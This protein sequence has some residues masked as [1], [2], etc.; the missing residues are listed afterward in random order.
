MTQRHVFEVRY[1]RRDHGVFVELKM[2]TLWRLLQRHRALKCADTDVESGERLKKRSLAAIRKVVAASF[3]IYAICKL[4]IFD[5]DVFLV[6]KISPHYMWVVE[7][8][9]LIL[10]AAVSTALLVT[11]NKYL[12][13]WSLYILF[14]PF[15]LTCWT[16]PRS[17]FKTGDWLFVF[18][19][20]NTIISAFSSIKYKFVAFSVFILSTF[21]IFTSF[22]GPFDRVRHI[23]GE[24]FCAAKRCSR[25]RLIAVGLDLHSL[26]KLAVLAKSSRPIRHQCCTLG[27]QRGEE[28][29]HRR[30]VPDVA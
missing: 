21:A 18:A 7:Y 13:G 6:N 20:A 5:I 26:T 17:A 4:F 14:Y 12:L 16:L 29:L 2:D 28:A 10:L 11:K 15:I 30:I 23:R 9:F 1:V 24:H 25:Q 22:F 8:K 27:L 19:L 3:W